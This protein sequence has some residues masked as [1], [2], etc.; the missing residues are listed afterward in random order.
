M[1]ILSGCKKETGIALQNNLSNSFLDSA[2]GFLKESL[3]ANEFSKLDLNSL[4][5]LQYRDKNLGIKVFQKGNSTDKFLMVGID[6]GDYTASWV[7][8]SAFKKRGTK[9][10]DGSINLESLTKETHTM[11]I[12]DS[13]K[14]I[15]SIVSDINTSQKVI[16]N[17]P[18]PETGLNATQSVQGNPWLPEIV[19]VHDGGSASYVSM[20]WMLN[21]K[22]YFI[23]VFSLERYDNLFG[24]IGTGAKL[25]PVIAVPKFISP[26]RPIVDLATELKC[27]TNNN[28]SSYSISVNVRQPEPNTREVVDP[29]STFPV[30]HTFLTLQQTNPDGSTVVRNLGFYPKNGV[31]PGTSVDQSIFGDD[32]NTSY[33]VSIKFSVSGSEFMQVIHSLNNQ[34]VLNYDLDNFNCTNSAMDALNNIN[35]HLPSTLSTDFLFHGNDPADL[36]E[37]LRNLDIDKFNQAN[38]NRQVTRSV[39]NFNNQMPPPKKGTC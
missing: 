34:Q 26:D 12:I 11:L 32:S 19:V 8:L 5:I 13:N 10:Y 16:T 24:Q 3:P 25:A 17:Y 22:N 9:Y 23:N 28:S 33:D 35:I 36:G 6:V 39:S 29:F 14:V 37:D 31:K 18:S 15:Q 21:Q 27:F 1:I 30:G 20:F 38:G 2:V 7:D 4:E